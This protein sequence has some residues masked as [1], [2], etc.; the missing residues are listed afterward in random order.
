MKDETN[1]DQNS[2]ASPSGQTPISVQ[3]GSK[4]TASAGLSEFVKPSEQAKSL[5]REVAEAG[6]QQVAE[7][8]NLDKQ[9]EQIGVKHSD[10]DTPVQTEPTGAVSLPMTDEEAE[11]VMKEYK[12]KVT[13]DFGQHGEEQAYIIP[14]KLGLATLVHKINKLFGFLRRRTA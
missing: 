10:A 9:H 12:N 14:S 7:A 2:T 13:T 11:N 4:E 3:V 8:P 1:L 6:V 5:D